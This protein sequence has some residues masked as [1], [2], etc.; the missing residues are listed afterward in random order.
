MYLFI[1]KVL[2]SAVVIAIASELA[3]RYEFWSAVLI[4]L[5]L[6][7][8]LAFVWIYWE[9]KD[10]DKVIEMSYSVFW[11]VI[12]SLV[13]FLVLPFLLKAGVRFIPAML[14]SAAV[15]VCLYLGGAWAYK[16]MTAQA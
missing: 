8:I 15:L 9:T 11:L 2:I 16:Y 7:S 13:F 1:A 10:A 14:G 3:N 12:P 6:T 5:P 4:S